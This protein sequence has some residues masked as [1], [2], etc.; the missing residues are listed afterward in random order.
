MAGLCKIR[1][2]RFLTFEKSRWRKTKEH[3][4]RLRVV[5]VDLTISF[6]TQMIFLPLKPF[7]ESC[8]SSNRLV[9]VDCSEVNRLRV[10]S[11]TVSTAT[12]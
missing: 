3:Y 11:A 1:K 2:N 8:F 5:K 10:V 9:S 6:Q 12:K 7:N 4:D